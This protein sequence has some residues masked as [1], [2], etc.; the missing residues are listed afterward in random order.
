[1]IAFEHSGL[2]F[3]QIFSKR[4]QQ[5]RAFKDVIDNWSNFVRATLRQIDPRISHVDLE[6]LEQDV[7]LKLWNVLISEGQFD[8]PAAF[9]R[10]LVL[11]V[12]IDAARKRIVR[13]GD[14]PHSS[15]SEP[16]SHELLGAD[17]MAHEAME[18]R[19]ELA[20]VAAALMQ[21]QPETA[22]AMSLYLQGFSTDEIG[23]LL[24]WTEAKARNSVY[25]LIERQRVEKLARESS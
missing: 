10:K 25:R 9:I 21:S 17:P 12:S 4:R 3:S 5:E 22:Q 14:A 6:E 1:L 2:F 7:R 15:L 18:Y 8:K 13:G 16:D 24:G 23:K 11:N 20:Q 19:V